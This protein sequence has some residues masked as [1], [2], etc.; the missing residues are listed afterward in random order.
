M[1][2]ADGFKSA[3]DVAS[4]R[5]TD[6]VSKKSIDGLR[7]HTSI[8]D[9]QWNDSVGFMRCEQSV[10]VYRQQVATQDPDALFLTHRLARASYT[11]AL[12]ASLAGVPPR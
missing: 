12:T 9:L 8:I 6:P 10:K 4:M 1:L 5:K 7:G 11:A 3:Y 2:T